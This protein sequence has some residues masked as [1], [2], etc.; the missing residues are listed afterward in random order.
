MGSQNYHRDSSQH[1]FAH[2]LCAKS[3]SFSCLIVVCVPLVADDQQFPAARPPCAHRGHFRCVDTRFSCAGVS[4]AH[5]AD[6]KAR[7][8]SCG[9]HHASRGGECQ[10]ER[11]FAL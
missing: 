8:A 9:W 1:A 4:R 6:K 5:C 2:G 7:S 3:P 10:Y 11:S